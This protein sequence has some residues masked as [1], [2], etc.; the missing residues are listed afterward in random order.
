MFKNKKKLRT[1]SRRQYVSHKSYTNPYFNEANKKSSKPLLSHFSWKT[2]F[3]VLFFFALFA[4]LFWFFIYSKYFLIYDISINFDRVNDIGG[5]GEEQ[6]E[7]IAREQLRSKYVFFPGNNFF[8]FKENALYDKL[9]ED[10][11]FESIVVNKKFPNKLELDLKE[12]SY[13]LVWFEDSRYYY[14]TT[15]GEIIIEVLP[16]ELKQIFPLI[17]N[18]GRLL[19]LDQRVAGKEKHFEYAIKLYQELRDTNIFNVEKFTVGNENDNTLTMK[20]M[21]G[22]DVYFNVEE[23]IDQQIQ[24]LILLRNEKLRDEL[25]SKTYIDLRFGDMIYYR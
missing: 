7:R 18:K 10:L 3:S 1:N 20:I 9:K 23:G 13:A 2:K 8:L 14:I 6:I 19:I 11:A 12:V 16:E 17:E 5:I 25:F 22:P 24:K 21:D 4:L 15:N